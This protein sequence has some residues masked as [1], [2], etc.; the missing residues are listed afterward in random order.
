MF[1]LDTSVLSHAHYSR[2][3]PAVGQ[4][5]DGQRHLAI[6]FPVILEVYIGIYEAQKNK[7]LLAEEILGWL[8]D[9]LSADFF[10]PDI[11]REVS[12]ILA[13]LYCHNEL[14]HLWYRD[15]ENA[16]KRKPGQDLFIAAISIAHDIPIASLDAKDFA[17]INRH[18]HLPGVYN[19]AFSSWVVPKR[20]N[21]PIEVT[22][23]MEVA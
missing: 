3:H 5:L 14:R 13:T 15:P 8:D 23:D 12:R 16:R 4:W 1:L 2:Q 22:D 6:P 10:Y 19:P 20:Q 11:N 17:L 18:V 21:A 9:V 7:P